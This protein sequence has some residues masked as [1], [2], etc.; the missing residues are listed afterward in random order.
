MG[1]GWG[2][3]IGVVTGQR[4]R[5]RPRPRPL[6]RLRT[7]WPLTAVFV[8]YP[9][10]WILGVSNFVAFVAAGFMLAELV[11]RRRILVPP[12]FGFWLMFLAVVL[13]G[14]VLL[15]VNAPGALPVTSRSG[16]IT[17]S[18]RLAWY[19]AAT[20]A[21][22]YVGNM[23]DEL[24]INRVCRSLGWMFVVIVGGGWLGVL[25]PTL[26]FPSALELVLP[27]S[28]TSIE[29]VH[30]LVHPQVVQLYEG[31]VTDLPRP[32]AP[33]TF[34][35]FWG[36]NYALFLP[37][38]VVGWWQEAT[39]RRRAVMLAV[40][41]L[42]VVPVVQSLNRGLWATLGVLV[43]FTAIRAVMAGKVRLAVVLVT[44]IGVAVV[45]LASGPAAAIVVSRLDNPTSNEG[46]GMLAVQTVDSLVRGSPVVGFGSTR[47]PQSSF[48]S[49]AG[50]NTPDCQL[51]T[52]PALGTQ[53]HLWLVLYSQGILGLLLYLGLFVTTAIRTWRSR[54]PYV[55][56]G[57]A[58]LLAHAFT[59]PI[60][61]TVG[62]ALLAI[63]I[64]VG[65]CWRVDEQV[66]GYRAVPWRD[67]I[68]LA[69]TASYGSLARRN[70]ALV[71]VF[72]ALGIDGG[73]LWQTS[74]GVS[75]VGTVS[76]VLPV[77]PVF[78]TDGQRPST[79]DNEAQFARSAQVL[80]A[81]SSAVGH[82]VA[83]ND[84]IVSANAN[85]RILN[86][87]YTARTTEDADAGTKAAATAVLQRRAQDLRDRLASTSASLVQ[88]SAALQAALS[89][90]D[91]ST[92]VLKTASQR[93]NARAGADPRVFDDARAELLTRAGIVTSRLAR[94]E[95]TALDAG[96]LVRPVTTRIA[97]GR[98]RVSLISGAMVGLFVGLFV[99]RCR[100]QIG[101]PLGRRGAV[102]SVGLPLLT[103]L[104]RQEVNEVAKRPT[105]AEGSPDELCAGWRRAVGVAVAERP[106]ACVAVRDSAGAGL[107]AGELERW[108]DRAEL[109][110]KRGEVIDAEDDPGPTGVLLVA[111]ADQRVRDLAGARSELEHAGQQVVGVVLV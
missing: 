40:L 63:L 101:R 102:A 13:V 93:D 86:L 99:A 109:A 85:T 75:A 3:S 81:M 1:K 20:I 77:E 10:W 43:V 69:T 56:V 73:L 72:V 71:L 83:R 70:L 55:T 67:R 31:A 8:G 110:R 15:Q 12:G 96:D 59:S 18:Y 37:F 100:E 98:F 97:G 89:T 11:R 111:A 21:L 88:Q 87:R 23:R 9:L 42:S 35:N 28:V 46:R 52:P 79:M 19:L 6:L 7:G 54:S 39:R 26:D 64:A 36:L 33:F 82:R 16:V 84:V 51:C 50:G 105:G 78:L 57:L 80:D 90:L 92:K 25:M 104:D 27:R 108:V 41:G 44:V 38:F 62:V 34:T 91:R 60:Y 66:R 65:L 106:A 47:N 5:R 29:F 22:L 53:G 48:Y 45:G 49:I 74:R 17:W 68:A 103:R 4:P 76:I 107:V 95:T 94:A 2:V 58:V 32:S 24:P 30:I 14:V 61:D